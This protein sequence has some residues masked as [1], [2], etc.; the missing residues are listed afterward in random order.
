MVYDASKKMVIYHDWRNM[1][2]LFT[3]YNAEITGLSTYF[4]DTYNGVVSFENLVSVCE[5]TTAV[6]LSQVTMLYD[7]NGNRVAK[8]EKSF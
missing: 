3:F 1:P 7:A 2:V 6:K 4:T 8:L 5:A